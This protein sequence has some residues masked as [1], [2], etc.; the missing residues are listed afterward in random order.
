LIVYCVEQIAY[1]SRGRQGVMRFWTPSEE[2]ACAEVAKDPDARRLVVVLDAAI[3]PAVR[4]N[5]ERAS[6]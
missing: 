2:R 1:D 6:A 3:P 5:L 4:A